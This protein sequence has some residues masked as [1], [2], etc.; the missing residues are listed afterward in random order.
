MKNTFAPAAFLAISISTAHAGALFYV[1]GPDPNTFT[2][3]VL[4]PFT[5]SP[6]AVGSPATLG[7]GS[8]AF[9]GGLVG[10][11]GGVLYGIANDSNAAGSLYTIQPDGALSLVGAMGGLGFGFFGG[12][13]YNAANSTLYA[14]V[15]DPDGNSTLYSI[16]SGGAATSTGLSLGTGFSG[17][18]FDDAD[19]LFYGVGNDSSGY[20][21]L[22]DFSLGGPVNEVARL[23]YGFGA[24]SYDATDNVLWVIDPVNNFGSQL[25]QISSDGTVSPSYLTFG[26]GFAGLAVVP[27]ASATPE[28]SPSAMLGA[29]LACLTF[30]SRRMTAPVLQAA[31]GEKNE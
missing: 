26:D 27:P 21:I 17:L 7:D 14:A 9:N 4:I 30:F 3:D 24:L 2:P 1:I 29:A 6:P 18:A 20:S 8:L 16:D 25:F 11:P 15:N 12:L 10:G 23:G 19:G 5:I 31:K 22:Y 13:A 28:P